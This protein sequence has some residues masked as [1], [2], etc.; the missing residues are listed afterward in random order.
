MPNVPLR[1]NGIEPWYNAHYSFA[2]PELKFLRSL[3]KYAV[4][5]TPTIRPSV[6]KE[7]SS[8][9]AGTPFWQKFTRSEES[10][11]VA[12]SPLNVRNKVV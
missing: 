2:R 11:I 3:L 5:T 12:G 8:Q 1:A 9:I 7:V 6:K 4:Q 10:S